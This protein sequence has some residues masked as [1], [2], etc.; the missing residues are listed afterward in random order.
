MIKESTVSSGANNGLQKYLVSVA[1]GWH[2]A[3]RAGCLRFRIGADPGNRVP[4][5][6]HVGGA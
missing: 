6:V 1:L 4:A 5:F 3:A 2:V